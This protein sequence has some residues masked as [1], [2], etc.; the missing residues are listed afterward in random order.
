MGRRWRLGPSA[1][2]TRGFESCARAAD[3]FS[4]GTSAILQMPLEPV[5]LRASQCAEDCF[6]PLMQ[7][8]PS[9]VL[10][11]FV[12]RAATLDSRHTSNGVNAAGCSSQP[13]HPE[14]GGDAR[15]CRGSRL[16]EAHGGC[17][18]F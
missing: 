13:C 1:L 15:V 17:G 4:F 8:R 12:L 6:S 7:L 9:E 14:L 11:I 3:I 16:D 10:Y 18:D 5:M 2:A